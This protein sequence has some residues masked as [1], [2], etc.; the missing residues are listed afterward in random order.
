MVEN[1]S[2]SALF[3]ACVLSCSAMTSSYSST[4]LYY[5]TRTHSSCNNQ[6]LMSSL[7]TAKVSETFYICRAH[8]NGHPRLEAL[9]LSQNIY[10]CR[11]T[12]TETPSSKSARRLTL[13]CAKSE[14][15]S[16]TDNN[17]AVASTSTD[18]SPRDDATA[19]NAA[20]RA[21]SVSE[22]D[23]RRAGSAPRM[24]GPRAA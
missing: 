23:D 10:R 13:G 1:N 19:G 2:K 8:R 11:P 6:I 7:T 12:V 24:A 20:L 17:L 22:E 15:S 9:M 4:L 21:R 5:P 16:N 18:S 3:W 14:I